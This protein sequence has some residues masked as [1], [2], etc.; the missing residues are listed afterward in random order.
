[1]RTESKPNLEWKFWGFGAKYLEIC[2][3]GCERRVMKTE[4]YWNYGP[5]MAPVE[6]ENEVSMAPHT[7]SPVPVHFQCVPPSRYL[8]SDSEH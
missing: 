4:K 7:R 1:M 8:D 6:H 3:L 2:D 5:V